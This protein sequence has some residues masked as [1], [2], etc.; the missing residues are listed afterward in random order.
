MFKL[1]DKKIIA[2]LGKLILLH[3]PYG[4]SLA[5]CTILI[6]KPVSVARQAGLNLTWLETL[7]R[8]FL[9]MRPI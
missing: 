3:W 8:G 6:F 2:I 4:K 7:K 1:I 5:A 9:A